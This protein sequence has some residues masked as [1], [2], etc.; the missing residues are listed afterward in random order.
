MT[1]A[2]GRDGWPGNSDG[3]SAPMAPHRAPDVQQ[4]SKE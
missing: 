2:P 4:Q 1:Q 3:A